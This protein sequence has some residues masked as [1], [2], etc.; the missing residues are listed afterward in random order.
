[1]TYDSLY[2]T[3]PCDGERFNLING[4]PEDGNTF[5]KD[6]ICTVQFLVRK[7]QEEGIVTDSFKIE[8]NFTEINERD[9]T[10]ILRIQKIPPEALEV[11]I[12]LPQVQ[13]TYEE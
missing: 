4:F 1:M 12:A 10:L 11:L 13:L 2:L 8:A 6:S 9:S 5:L 3:C 7:D